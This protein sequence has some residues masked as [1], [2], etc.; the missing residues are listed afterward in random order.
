[1]TVGYEGAEAQVIYDL[2]QWGQASPAAWA[3]LSVADGDAARTRI[4]EVDGPE[5]VA[6]ENELLAHIVIDFPVL[7]F[8]R[9]AGGAYTGTADVTLDFVLP[10][11]PTDDEAEIYRRAARYLAALRR[12]LLD[13][14]DGRILSV[15]VDPT[16]M[17]LD[18]SGSQAGTL[19]FGL[20]LSFEVGP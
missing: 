4:I 13:R 10:L 19:E 7:R 2:V 20:S 12:D 3:F 16:P 18:A 17:V 1:M 11:T 14:F 15:A 9:T 5:P 6:G 8:Q